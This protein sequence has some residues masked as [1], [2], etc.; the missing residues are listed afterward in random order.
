MHLHNFA[1]A[2][3]CQKDFGGDVR[4][5]VKFSLILIPQML[6]IART[7]F[8]SLISMVMDVTPSITTNAQINAV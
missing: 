2:S 8:A 3:A 1:S 7:S 5:L 4:G 6:R